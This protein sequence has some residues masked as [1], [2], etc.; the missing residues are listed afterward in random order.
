MRTINPDSKSINIFFGQ[1]HQETFDEF[2]SLAHSLRRSRTG[3][4]H[5]L[6]SHYKWYEKYRKTV[7][8]P[9]QN[10]SSLIRWNLR[11]CRNWQSGSDWNLINTSRRSCRR[12]M[13]NSSKSQVL[14]KINFLEQ[15]LV[16]LVHFLP[17][18]YEYLMVELDLQKR[19]LAE[20]EVSET[21]K[22]IEAEHECPEFSSRQ[23]RGQCASLSRAGTPFKKGSGT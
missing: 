4:L 1:K 16:S 12:N 23:T 15:Q 19:Q 14:A 17:E 3:T 5:F 7:V 11:C 9:W 10:Q 6:L 18:T 20:I 13:P 22:Q 21:Y 2:E 8:W